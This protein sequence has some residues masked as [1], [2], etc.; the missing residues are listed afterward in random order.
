MLGFLQGNQKSHGVAA[1]RGH[2]GDGIQLP[3]LKKRRIP[4]VERSVP[5]AACLCLISTMAGI[6]GSTASQQE[7]VLEGP[8]ECAACELSMQRILT[9]GEGIPSSEGLMCPDSSRLAED[10]RGRFFVGPSCDEQVLVY[11]AAGKLLG[12]LGR[13]GQGPGEFET[14]GYLWVDRQDRL[15]VFDRR[16]N[17][18]SIFSPGL[19]LLDS[20][21]IPGPPNGVLQGPGDSL[22]LQVPVSSR[23]YAGFPILEVDTRGGVVSAFGAINPSYRFDRAP[24]LYLRAIAEA[25]NNRVW[26]GWAS[27]YQIELW[28]VETGSLLNTMKRRVPWFT[29]WQTYTATAP[30]LRQVHVDEEGRLWT[31]TWVTDPDGLQSLDTDPQQSSP[32][33]LK[34]DSI[35]E[36]IDPSEQ[37]VLFSARHDLLIAYLLSGNRAV[38]ARE[39]EEGGLLL[40]VWQ[41]NP[42]IEGVSNVNDP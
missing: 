17:R 27:A 41:L 16:H 14:I 35:V 12:T 42:R 31:L 24:Y 5:L 22:L 26:S 40:D 32:W 4:V 9:I 34:H 10:S 25:G 7:V 39:D 36:I 8:A 11:D 13:R 33:H 38:T 6:A 20:V 30:M 2:R 1:S 18:M 19:D 21:L 29:E 3:W 23:E 15:Y 37:R 28:D